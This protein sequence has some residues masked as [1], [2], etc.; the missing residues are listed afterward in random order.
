LI[1]QAKEEAKSRLVNDSDK[2]QAINQ[3]AP[4]QKTLFN[5]TSQAQQ[6]QAQLA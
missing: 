2:Q 5:Q 6:M 4:L 1:E 3:D